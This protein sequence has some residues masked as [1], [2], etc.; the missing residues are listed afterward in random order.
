MIIATIRL[1]KAAR[2]ARQPARL[3]PSLAPFMD[4][5]PDLDDFPVADFVVVFITTPSCR[6]RRQILAYSARKVSLQK[7]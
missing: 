6:A 5:F 7:S 4:I 3:R 1:R 2:L